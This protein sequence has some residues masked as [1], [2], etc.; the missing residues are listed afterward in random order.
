ME[1]MSAVNL[2]IVLVVHD[3]F[4]TYDQLIGK[5]NTLTD[6]NRSS[7]P[8]NQLDSSSSTPPHQPPLHSPSSPSLSLHH[9]SSISDYHSYLPSS[10]E[11]I[12]PLLAFSSSIFVQLSYFCIFLPLILSVSDFLFVELVL[13]H[14]QF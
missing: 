10:P 7:K 6:T 9:A 12:V 5:V 13:F 11:I 1:V 2:L 4:L 8:S 14:L 3:K